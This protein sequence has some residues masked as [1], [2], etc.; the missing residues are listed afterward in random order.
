MYSHFEM[1]QCYISV[2]HVIFSSPFV[3]HCND[4]SPQVEIA[5]V[6]V[7]AWAKLISYSQVGFAAVGLGAWG[8]LS[9]SGSNKN[10]TVAPNMGSEKN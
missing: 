2:K 7:F 8:P 9:V 1:V 5:A 4:S 10:D 3:S 6:L